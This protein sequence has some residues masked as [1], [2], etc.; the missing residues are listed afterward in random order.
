M[1][2][3]HI[4]TTGLAALAMAHA[5]FAAPQ[6]L[7]DIVY[8]QGSVGASGDAQARDLKMDAYLPDAPLADTGAPAVIL[9]FGGAFHRGDKGSGTFTEDGARN[10][11]MARYCSKIAAAG[12][13]CF[14]IEYRLTPEDPVVE[15]DH[16]S[17]RLFPE[18]ILHAP[19]A[20]AR[21][22][23]ARTQMGLDPLDETSRAQY[24]HAI[25]AAAEDM[26]K[27]LEHVRS[28]AGDYDIDPGRIA[29]GGFSAGAITAINTAYGLDAPVRAVVSLSGTVAGYNPGAG[30][31]ASPP[32]ILMIA[33]Q[34]DL[35]GIF[36]GGQYLHQTLVA[37]GVTPDTAWVPGFGHFYPA[38][39]TTLGAD[40]TRQTVDERMI[41]FLKRE[42][43]AAKPT[44]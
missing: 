6:V 3:R 29:V 42:L 28:Q 18:E 31:P 20:T 13:A 44:P 34:N 41:G 12:I 39:A 22:D 10:T 9:A 4:L 43:G 21:I 7:G 1:K 33:G 24:W 30:L 11:S 37:S 35:P 25:L 36:R 19:G 15:L 14:S 38:E 32:P 26:S 40:L 2:I 23:F 17:A 5:A 8:G 16:T 27:A